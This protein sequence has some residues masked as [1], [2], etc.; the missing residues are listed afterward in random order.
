MF[1]YL[2]E[3]KSLSVCTC[4]KC[5]STSL[6]MTLYYA[7]TGSN[8]T[9]PL[10]IHKYWL[11]GVQNVKPS[12]HYG[13][14]HLIMTRD[15]VER[16]VS[17]YHSKIKCC[18][19]NVTRCYNDLTDNLAPKLLNIAGFPSKRCMNFEEYVVVLE[20]IHKVNKVTLMNEH[21]LP[22][23]LAC[24]IPQL[25]PT[26]VFDVSMADKFFSRL[27]GYG[28]HPVQFYHEHSTPRPQEVDTTRLRELARKEYE[29]VDTLAAH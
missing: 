26:L 22:Q 1:F 15:P 25:T 13:D 23:H 27:R 5:G 29:F 11:W 28:M 19:D 18:E 3:N 9:R 10:I 7:I 8:F 17:T 20:K 6:F 4:A 21:F 14:L 2:F 12:N 24:P 16:Y